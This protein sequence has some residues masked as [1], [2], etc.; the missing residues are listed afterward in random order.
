MIEGHWGATER[1]DEYNRIY[2]RLPL[3]GGRPEAEVAALVRASRL[4]LGRRGAADESRTV[5]RPARPSA[6]PCNRTRVKRPPPHVG[7]HCLIPKR[8]M[9]T[10]APAL[11]ALARVGCRQ[12][13]HLKHADSLQF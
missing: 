1:R 11:D 13:R 7:S 8:N 6:L 3:F 4:C 2:A 12:L 9:P 10:V 5:D